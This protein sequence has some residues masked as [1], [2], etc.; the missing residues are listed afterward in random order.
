[1]AGEYVEGDIA[2]KLIIDTL[3]YEELPEAAVGVAY[4]I[5]A[6]EAADAYGRGSKFR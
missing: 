5:F 3:G 4:P 2:P 6:Y 1:M